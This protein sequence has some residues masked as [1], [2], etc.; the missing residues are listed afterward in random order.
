MPGDNRRNASMPSRKQ[1]RPRPRGDRRQPSASRSDREENCGGWPDQPWAGLPA[2]RSTARVPRARPSQKT[3]METHGTAGPRVPPG[4]AA[5]FSKVCHR[6]IRMSASTKSMRPVSRSALTSLPA[7]VTEAIAFCR[8]L[9]KHLMPDAVVLKV[10]L[11]ELR[12]MHQPLD[13]DLVEG[14]KDAERYHRRNRSGKGLADSVT[15]VVTLQPVA[16]VA[17]RLVGTA[18]GLRAVHADLGPFARC[19]ARAGECRLDRAMYQEVRIAP[20]R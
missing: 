13:I 17:R 4:W 12:N 3:P 5:A 7:A 2:S 16:D 20:D 19:V 11:A 15:H 18:L 14:D 1:P 6:Q 10:I 8:A 9:A